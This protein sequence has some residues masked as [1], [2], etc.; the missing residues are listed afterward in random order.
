MTDMEWIGL[1]EGVRSVYANIYAGVKQK[2]DKII[3]L[4][5]GMY[6]TSEGT[7]GLTN[8]LSLAC[9]TPGTQSNYIIH[10]YSYF[11]NR[12]QLVVE[13]HCNH[14]IRAQSYYTIWTIGEY[15]QFLHK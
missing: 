5:I 11:M 10:Q 2:Y 3:A 8:C 14:I 1:F 4:E 9:T 6:D 13:Q 15:E 7:T 12:L